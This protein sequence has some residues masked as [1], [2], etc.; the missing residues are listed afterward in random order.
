[1]QPTLLVTTLMSLLWLKMFNDFKTV[2]SFLLVVRRSHFSPGN[3]Q[4]VSKCDP[5]VSAE[6]EQ[7]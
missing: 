7:N 4:K 2:K 5:L 6:P 1:M 3:E